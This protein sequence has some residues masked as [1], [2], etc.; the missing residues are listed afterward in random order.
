MNFSHLLQQD[1][2]DTP[3]LMGL[4]IHEVA[5]LCCETLL[6][7]QTIVSFNYTTHSIPTKFEIIALL[8]LDL[9]KH[10]IHELLGPA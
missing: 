4:A 8:S 6:V 5:N 7:I 3:L 10:R 9:E 2:Q 1:P